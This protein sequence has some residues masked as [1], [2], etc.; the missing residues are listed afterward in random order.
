MRKH[1]TETDCEYCGLPVPRSVWGKPAPG[2][3][4]CCTGCRIAHALTQEQGEEGEARWMLTKLGLAIFFSMNVMVLTLALWAY[5]GHSG[6]SKVLAESLSELFRFTCLLL[7]YPVLFLLGRPLLEQAI[8]QW[9]QRQFSTDLLILSGVV[10]SFGYSTVSVWRGHGDIYFEVGCMILVFVTLGRWFEATGKLWST[11]ALDKL[12]QLLPGEV[13]VRLSDGTRKVIS[14]SSLHVGDEVF[15]RPGER[16]PVDGK[17]V[18]GQSSV[19]EQLVTGESWPVLK[20]AADSVVG[21][22]LAL[23]GE[24][25]VRMDVAL[26]NSVLPRLV[27]AVRK[28]RLENGQ[29]QRLADRVSQYFVPGTFLLACLVGL[30][31]AIATSAMNGVLAGLAVVLIACP[32]ALGIAT[33][34]ALWAAMGV[35]AQRGIVFRNVVSLEKLASIKAV[36]FDKTGTLTTGTPRVHHLETDRETDVACIQRRAITLAT[37]SSHIFSRAIKRFLDSV[38]IQQSIHPTTV[39]GNGLYAVWPGEFLPTVLGNQ[40]FIEDLELDCPAE[41]QS[42]LERASADGHPYALIGWGGVVRGV[43]QFEEEIRDSALEMVQSCRQRRLDVGILTGD[44]SSAA[45]RFGE[46]AGV[47]VCSGLTPEQKQHALKE[48]QSTIG[49]V[50]LVGDGINDAPA[51]ATADVGISLGCGADVSRESAD[52]CL[53]SD[54]LSQLPWLFDLAETTI[55]TVRTNL[56]WAFAYNGLGVLVAASGLLH[57]AVAAALMVISSLF[58]ISNSLRL[59]AMAPRMRSTVGQDLP[60]QSGDSVSA[61]SLQNRS[62][63]HVSGVA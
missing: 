61:Q 3:H 28:A 30:Y 11:D 17:V 4:Y 20:T 16:I 19:D 12:Q 7:S 39:P 60:P 10:A 59:R 27:E 32:C 2:L 41:L 46:R 36:R 44:S 63:R 21:G 5:D 25:V 55:R 45:S 38:E 13:E 18:S 42:L 48:V 54:D 47:S 57:P 37:A 58:V 6:E 52:V 50:A 26:E 34:M 15:I 35:A 62:T 14:R 8:D 9:R 53:V 1:D 33:P 29:Y 24:L 31:H 40:R 49:P 22:T 56:F 43:F 51:L 23:D